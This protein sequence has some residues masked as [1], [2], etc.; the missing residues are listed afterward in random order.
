MTRALVVA[1]HVYAVALAL[2]PRSLRDRYG[3]DMR[4]TFDALSADAAAR[5]PL[6]LLTLLATET[7]DVARST[8]DAQM[9]ILR[10]AQDERRKNSMT[11]LFQ[12]LRYAVRLLRRQPGFALVAIMTLA[13]G[14]GANTAVFTVINGVLLRPLPYADPDRLVTLLNGRN[15]RLSAAFSPPNYLDITTQSGVFAGAAA[16][17]PT[18]A[19][20]TGHGDPQ[21]LEG[22]D[23]TWTFFQVLGVTP[24][25]GRTFLEADHANN[26]PVVV[27]SDG[28]WRQ[29]GASSDI[30]DRVVTLDGMPFTVIGVAPPAMAIPRNAVYWRPLVLAPANFAPQARGAQFIFVLGRLRPDIDLTAANSAMATVANR[31][32]VDFPRT[33]QGRAMTAVRMQER[34]VSG[35]RPALRVLLGAVMVVLLIACVNVANLLLARAH[36]RT[37]EVAVRAALGAGRR[38]L[39]QQ[40][41]AESLV[42]GV[43]GGLVGLVVAFWATRALVALGPSSVPR[44]AEVT[45]DWRVL[46]FT[47]G[48]ALATSV[49]FGLV[50]AMASAGRGATR[51]ISSAGR[52]SVGPGGTRLRK[53]LVTAEFALAVVLLAGAGLLLR[54]YQRISAVDPGFVPDRVLT[55][56]LAL[57]SA[58]YESNDAVSRFMADYVDRLAHSPG[59]ESAAAVFGLPLADD[60][61][62]S[63]S[64]TRP[65]ETDTASSPSLGM[66]V[67][68][69]DYFRTL[70]IPLRS[71]RVF[72]ARDDAVGPEVVVINEEAARRYWPNL[73]PIGQQLHLGVRLVSGVRSGQK[74]IVG[75]VSDVKFGALDAATPPEVYLPHAQHPVPDL[76]I[77]VRGSGEPLSLVPTAR[78]SLGAMDREL[79]M[80]DIRTRND[81]VGRSIAERR[82]VM[83]LIG[84][85]ATLA[86]LLAAIGIYGVL[87]YLVTQRVQ[88]IGVRLAIGASPADVVRLFVREGAMLTVIGLACGLAGALAAAQ[89]LN[90]LLFG[91]RATDPSTF[92][93][94]AVALALVAF[95]ASYVP[96]RRAARVDPMTAL[97]TD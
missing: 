31:L 59:A 62:A 9:L 35:I 91:V 42:L 57:P 23:V 40:F 95:V 39:I 80:A 89:A 4:A 16:F 34:M 18:T 38:R 66:R 24:R 92:A 44:L 32:A 69:P 84:T 25:L 61:S 19:N 77:A 74:T 20:L 1:R 36:G 2:W 51:S 5:G 28:L 6:A 45:L 29:L 90:S 78:T 86:V 63:S 54:S 67:I 97:R 22:A 60:F 88:E 8:P 94:V 14:I 10:Q 72:D 46:A 85:F 79:P 47:M 75:V 52:G 82:F 64:F 21:R 37:R 55:F 48:T 17:Q 73:N 83:L 7:L 58:K 27:I 96:A 30:V 56:N 33:N 41:L 81:L 76:T 26:A 71:G 50:P 53:I 68:T 65:G 93:G 3:R 11:S 43:G 70:K 49:V 15:G 87:A 12:D 13:L